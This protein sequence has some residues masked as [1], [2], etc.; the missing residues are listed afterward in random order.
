MVKVAGLE[1]WEA[2]LAACP[3]MKCALPSHLPRNF[4]GKHSL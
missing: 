1:G 4:L 2:A 3:A